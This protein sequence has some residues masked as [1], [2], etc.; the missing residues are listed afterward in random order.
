MVAQVL[1]SNRMLEMSNV[2][3]LD[4]TSS[5]DLHGLFF[6]RRPCW[7]VACIS[8]ESPVDAHQSPSRGPDAGDHVE[9]LQALLHEDVNSTRKHFRIKNVI[10]NV[11]HKKNPRTFP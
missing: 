5:K 7:S 2:H 10:I 4:W 6:S 3:V 11:P 9:V 8:V 1:N